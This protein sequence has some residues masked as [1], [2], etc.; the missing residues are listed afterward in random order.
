MEC[1]RS[2]SMNEIERHKQMIESSGIRDHQ[3]D[4]RRRRRALTM[5]AGQIPRAQE[6][7]PDPEPCGE[8]FERLL[9]QAGPTRLGSAAL[10]VAS[11]VVRPLAPAVRQGDLVAP[12]VARVPV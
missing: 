2:T 9:A 4:G 12:A 11:V 5:T 10:S 7:G 3:A 8:R 1:E 6:L